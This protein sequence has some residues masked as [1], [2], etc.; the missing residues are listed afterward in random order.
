[1]IEVSQ[2]ELKNIELN[3]LKVFDAFCKENNI[4]YFLSNGTLLGAVKYN[5]QIPWDDDIDVF[6]PRK[7]YNKLL[8]IFRDDERYKLFAF[9]YIEERFTSKYDLPAGS[10]TFDADGK[11]CIRN[12]VVGDYIYI[13]NVMQKAYQLVEYNGNYYFVTDGHKIAKN[14]TIYL[15]DNYLYEFGLP[16]GKYS[17][18]AE[19]KMILKNGPVDGKFYINGVA[20]NAY[21]LV[22]FE[23]YYYFIGDGHRIVKDCTIYLNNEFIYITGLQAG[24]YSFDSEGRLILN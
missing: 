14:C 22:E 8:E 10:Y 11:M 3:L 20:Q 6:L 23:G 18:D 2:N 5:G 13:N 1:M 4:T 17:F 12:G 7:D 16:A 9:I 24:Y 15:L 21:Q 19:G